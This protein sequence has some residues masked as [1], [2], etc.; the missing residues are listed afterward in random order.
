[1]RLRVVMACEQLAKEPT[2]RSSNLL[3]VK[4]NGEVRLRSVLSSKISGI[5]PTTLSFNS[6]FFSGDILPLS[7]F[8]SSSST[9]VSWLPMNTEIIAGG[10]SLAPKRWSLLAEA[11]AARIKSA[12]S[13]IALI[14]LTKK[15]KNKRLRFGV[16]PGASRLIPVSVASDQLLCLPEPL[17]PAKGFSCIS[18]RKLWRV[19]T[20]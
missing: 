14:V 18:T 10:A 5:L 1:M 9:S 8:S 15:L 19:P 17:T 13:C 3:P 20:F 12:R 7:S 16:E 4:A 2:A 11:M 6:V